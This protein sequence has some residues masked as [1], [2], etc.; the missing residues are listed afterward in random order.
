MFAVQYDKILKKV[1]AA[2]TALGQ[3][4]DEQDVEETT[5]NVL[6]HMGYNRYISDNF[7]PGHVR[8]YFYKLENLGILTTL[9]KQI[10]ISQ[11]SNWS[12][13]FWSFR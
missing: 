10:S 13:H 7:I 2:Y 11:K 8:K 12:I 3:D 1:K 5:K 9:T 6:Q 4:Y